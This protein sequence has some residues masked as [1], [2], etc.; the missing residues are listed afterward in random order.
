MNFKKYFFV[1]VIASGLCFS[2][3]AQTD[4]YIVHAIKKGETLSMLAKKYHTTVGDI[5]RL[6][7]MNTKSILK[8]GEK[9][10]IP[11]KN[12]TATKSVDKVEDEVLVKSVTN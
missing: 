5:M 8:I 4:D 11:I 6:N 12:T 2:A 3:K 7:S 9:V 1:F 10:K